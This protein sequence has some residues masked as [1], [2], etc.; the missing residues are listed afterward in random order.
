MREQVKADWIAAL[1]S[2]VYEQGEGKLRTRQGRFCCLGVLCDRYLAA[3]GLG[4][5]IKNSEGDLYFEAFGQGREGSY[6]PMAVAK[7]AGL[8]YANPKAGGDT[9][10]FQN[11]HGAS[12]DVIAKLIEKYL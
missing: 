6:P 10:A 12:F 9:L 4:G 3:T 1:R 7:W 8:T 2:G 11:D 5:W